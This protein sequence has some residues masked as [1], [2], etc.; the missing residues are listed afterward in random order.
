M[1]TH[2]RLVEIRDLLARHGATAV[3]IQ[4]ALREGD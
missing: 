2:E 1:N 4:P 3:T